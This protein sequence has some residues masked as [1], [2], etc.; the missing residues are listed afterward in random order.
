MIGK[1]ILQLYE[2]DST[3]NYA[4]KLVRAGKL[5]NGT[6]IL[7]E[8]Q[9]AGRG[10]RGNSWTSEG[11]NQFTATVYL[12]TAFLSVEDLPFFNMAVALAV[13]ATISSFNCPNTVIKWPNDIYI[14]S[15]KIAG[16]L[17]ETQLQSQQI[18]HALIGVGI[19]I[20][21]EPQVEMSDALSNWN[22]V[23]PDRLVVL[24]R[25]IAHMNEEILLFKQQSK[26]EIYARYCTVLWKLNEQIE[27]QLPDG[28][29]IK[30]TILG[31]NELGNL[32]FETEGTVKSF[33]IQEISFRVN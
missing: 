22:A 6:V 27:A 12:E 17:I 26:E 33:G 15:K 5:T 30:G 3:N 19:N 31:V 20:H 4:A 2:V 11:G 18:V 28:N 9:T 23:A 10:Q 24:E 32:I 21:T 7:A 8:R 29:R 16:I 1:R 14:D 13:R 25:F